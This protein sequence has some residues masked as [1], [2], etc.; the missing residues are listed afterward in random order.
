MNPSNA[1]IG[2]LFGGF[3]AVVGA[4]LCVLSAKQRG[5]A[6]AGAL[7]LTLGSMFAVGASGIQPQ[8]LPAPPIP[9]PVDPDIPPAPVTT[10]G[11]AVQ[12][13]FAG[14]PDEAHQLGELHV[15]FG[16]G[17]QFRPT[18]FTTG[19]DFLNCFV[20]AEKLQKRSEAPWGARLVPLSRVVDAE[21]RARGLDKEFDS[22]KAGALWIEIGEALEGMGP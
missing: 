7:A 17:T 16:F 13:S 21:L 2:E 4:I 15:A 19:N 18:R 6:L 14:T 20:E 1:L 3:V 10:F 22:A 11:R 12:L 5:L 9:S 8:P